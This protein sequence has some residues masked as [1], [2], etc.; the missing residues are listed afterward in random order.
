MKLNSGFN[1]P[2]SLVSFAAVL[3]GFVLEMVLLP[4]SPKT[5]EDLRWPASVFAMGL[6][7]VPLV[8]AYR[9]PITILHPQSVL[10]CGIVYWLLLDLIQA[11][12]LPQVAGRDAIFLGFSAVALFAG[13]VCL[14]GMIRAPRLPRI[15]MEAA[16]KPLSPRLIFRIGLIAFA[17]S[18]LRYAIPSGFDLV[19]M[20]DA[21]FLN[22]W[23]APWARGAY[24][25]WDAFLDHMAYFGYVLPALTVLHY[26]AA[27]RRNWQTAML[28]VFSVIIILFIAQ[29]GGRRIVGALLASAGV[30]WVLTARRAGRSIFVLS[31]AGIPALLAYLQYILFTRGAGMGRVSWFSPGGIFTQGVQVD[32]NFNRLCQ[33]IQIIPDHVKHTGFDWVIWFLARPI[34]RVLWP[35]KPT[36]LGFDLSAFLGMQG[37][38]LSS[39][40]IGESYIAFG[41][42]GCLVTGF[43]Y[44]YLGRGLSRL[45]ELKNQPSAVLMYALGLL[46]LFVGLRSAVEVMLFGYALLAWI[47]LAHFLARRRLR[48]NRIVVNPAGIEGIKSLPRMSFLKKRVG[49]SE[50]TVSEASRD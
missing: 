10:L 42:L 47:L 5:P 9:R 36:G 38:S 35:G 28:A 16:N 31:L 24:G 14:A 33:L 41:F 22:R 40:V 43:V 23:S 3:L 2:S 6:V 50:R 4:Y 29:G 30:V 27:G 1:E 34:P 37:V 49:G 18:F 8:A 12:Y 20:Y 11:L 45:L 46:A 25:G 48:R 15:L 32:D 39:S 44:G 13:G 17:L 7:I 21:L 19:R 26:R